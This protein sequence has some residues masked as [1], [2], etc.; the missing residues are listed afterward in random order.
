M[1]KFLPLLVFQ[2]YIKKAN[3]K[4]YSVY[5]YVFTYILN[6]L[7]LNTHTFLIARRFSPKVINKIVTQEFS[8]FSLWFFYVLTVCWS[9]SV[10]FSTGQFNSNILFIS[11]IFAALLPIKIMAATIYQSLCVKS[12]LDHISNLRTILEGRVQ[13]LNLTQEEREAQGKLN[14]PPK[15][16]HA[17]FDIEEA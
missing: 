9:L 1:F 8:L 4:E 17:G 2:E 5:V 10:Q 14:N 16:T 6:Y 3:N 12:V 15:V 7:L 13:Y 11:G